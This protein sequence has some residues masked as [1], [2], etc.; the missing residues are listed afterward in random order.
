MNEQEFDYLNVIPLVDVML[1][2]LTIVLTT[3]TFIATGSIQ[4]NL[5]KAEN[6][7]MAASVQSRTIVVDKDGQLWLDEQQLSLDDLSAA[8]SATERDT[9]LLL[10]ADK[11]LALQGFVAVYERIKVLG[12]T[13][14][15]LQT[16]QL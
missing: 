15:S 1:V 9:P 16:E 14:L 6:S 13:S 4:V 10:R 12:F 2:L 7:E 11:E 5:P 8:L 3:S